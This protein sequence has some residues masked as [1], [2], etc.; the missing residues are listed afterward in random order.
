VPDY[1]RLEQKPGNYLFLI[2]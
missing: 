2:I 1:L